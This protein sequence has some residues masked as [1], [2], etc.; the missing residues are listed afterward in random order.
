LDLDP[1]TAPEP[2]Y[3]A[4]L[5]FGSGPVACQPP[6]LPRPRGA[7]GPGRHFCGGLPGCLDRGSPVLGPGHDSH[8][9][10]QV[11]SQLTG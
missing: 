5:V 4:P 9:S 10:Q 6:A 7:G 11:P 2:K 8:H 1:L 3:V